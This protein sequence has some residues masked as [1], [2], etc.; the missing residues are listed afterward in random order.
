[1]RVL[2]C[3]VGGVV[4]LERNQQRSLP[5]LLCQQ[6]RHVNNQAP[7]AGQTV[8]TGAQWRQWARLKR[9]GMVEF[10]VR[11]AYGEGKGTS[12]RQNGIIVN[13][14]VKRPPGTSVCGSEKVGNQCTRN[15][16]TTSL[17]GSYAKVKP[18]CKMP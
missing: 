8:I 12:N 15:K 2:V 13:S 14:G 3:V 9:E 4:K 11:H 18:T 17:C 10:T 1:V 6:M 16:G 7:T 5:R